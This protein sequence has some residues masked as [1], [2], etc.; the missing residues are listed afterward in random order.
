M[1]FWFFFLFFVFPSFSISVGWRSTSRGSLV[2]MSSPSS[3]VLPLR[4]ALAPFSWASSPVYRSRRQRMAMTQTAVPVLVGSGRARLRGARG[5][6]RLGR[7]DAQ[8]GG[9]LTGELGCGCL[10]V[11][12]LFPACSFLPC[13][14][15][16]LVLC[17]LLLVLADFGGHGKSRATLV[18]CLWNQKVLFALRSVR[19]CLDGGFGQSP[20]A[21]Q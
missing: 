14:F 4:A 8:R 13:F 9:A 11:G 10:S 2:P 17:S 7:R 1:H 3:Q 15:L 12:R 20:M 19:F 6:A 21:V 16:V 18:S 5:C